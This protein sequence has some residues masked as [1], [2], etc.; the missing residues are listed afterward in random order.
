[1]GTH[2]N[3]L[4]KVDGRLFQELGKAASNGL[5]LDPIAYRQLGLDLV[6]ITAATTVLPEPHCWV[7][8]LGTKQAIFNWKLFKCVSSFPTKEGVF[9]V[10]DATKSDY[11]CSKVQRALDWH[12]TLVKTESELSPIRV[13]PSG[14][15]EAAAAHGGN[16]NA[17]SVSLQDISSQ[18]GS[19]KKTG[20]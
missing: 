5:P 3:F 11:N 13:T 17:P 8:W 1:M 19:L 20:I 10:A 15:D 9:E 4:A 2:G 18:L 6:L 7:C 14:V 16:S 12:V